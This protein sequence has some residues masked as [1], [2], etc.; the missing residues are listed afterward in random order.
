MKY[1]HRR[2]GD[3]INDVT[4]E[5]LSYIEQE[6]YDYQFEQDSLLDTIIEVGI[7]AVLLGAIGGDVDISSPSD[8]IEFG[9]GSFGGA[10]A[11]GDWW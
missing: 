9:G 4:Y 10:G 11:G 3:V 6:E 2:S 5:S 7:E 1:K 8:D